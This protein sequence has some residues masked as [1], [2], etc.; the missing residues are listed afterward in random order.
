MEVKGVAVV[1]SL[2]LAGCSRPAPA[3]PPR[4]VAGSVCAG[5]HAEI[6]KSYSQTGMG[7]S[8]Y[9]PS[10]AKTVED[11]ARRNRL[12][13]RPS[14]R[15]YT[16]MARDGQWFQ[17]RHEI[18]FDGKESNVLETRVDYVIG[19]GNHARS[20]LHRD[21]AGHLIEL[22]VSWYSENG[23]YWEMSPGYERPNQQDFR[24]AIAFSCLFCHNAYP[25]SVAAGEGIF[26]ETL[27]EGIDCQRCHGPGSGHVEAAG[28]K[29]SAET[30]RR[31]IVNPARLSRE[32]QLDVCMQCHLE[33]TSRPLPG[34][35]ARFEH[36]PFDYR[37]GQPLTDY[38][39]YFDRGPAE[40]DNFEIAHAAYR[41]RKSKCF[42]ASQM[43][44]TTCHN[45]HGF[46]Y[47]DVCRQCHASAHASGVPGNGDCTSCH[48]PRRRTEDAVHVVMTDH[49]IQRIQRAGREAY[50]TAVVP[51]YPTGVDE[52]YDAVAQ[53]RDGTNLGGGILQLR[54]AI[55]ERR[56]TQPGFYLELAK[57]YAKSGNHS[58]S[59]RWCEEA[60]RVRPGF[61]PAIDE[62]GAEWIQAGDF[63]RAVETLR[64]ASGP[65][66][67][68]NL[69]N[70]YLRLGRIDLAEQTLHTVPDDPD[71]DNLLGMIASAR[72]DYGAAEQFF[73]EALELQTDHAEAHQNL[74]NLLAMRHEYKEAAYHFGQAIAA[75]PSY[76]EAHHRYGLLLLAAGAVDRAQHEIEAAIRLKPGFTEAQRDLADILAAKGQRQR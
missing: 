52:L 11:Y 34:M 70:A 39:L 45:P 53:V 36:G 18:G 5:C 25:G 19:S 60:L 23:G 9:R 68:T 61:G 20:Y 15:S 27:P 22:P 49:Y 66:A 24:R 76:A 13:H 72:R 28:R 33:T 58:E 6:A 29:A 16:M 12:E 51:Y 56:P 46:R 30:I 55:E 1:V 59:V 7:R 57:A 44:C 73:R 75:N 65:A 71:A 32:R 17:R 50:P 74:A 40:D 10:A 2:Y 31:A 4:Y 41:L 37:P 43:T 69:G 3:P 21:G 14:G 8:F 62:L 48:M 42:Q 63:A 67:R 35:V 54:K 38:F 26:P 64:Q 47:K